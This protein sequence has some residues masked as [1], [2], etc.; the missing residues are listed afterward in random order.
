MYPSRGLFLRGLP[1]GRHRVH[2]PAILVTFRMATSTSFGSGS[3]I[4]RHCSSVGVTEST[5]FDEARRIGRSLSIA[6]ARVQVCKTKPTYPQFEGEKTLDVLVVGG[7]ITGLTAAYLLAKAGKSVALFERRTIGAGNTGRTTAH[8]Q[9]EV[10][11]YYCELEKIHGRETARLVGESQLAAV[12]FIER[13]T[14]EGARVRIR[15]LRFDPPGKRTGI[16]ERELHA[17]RRCG[18]KVDFV[19]RAPLEHFDTGRCLRFAGMGQFHPLK[20]IGGLADAA[21]RHGASIYEGTEM[22]RLENPSAEGVTAV[23][24]RA[25]DGSVAGRVRARRLVL[26]TCSPPHT[27]I[28]GDALLASRM[29]PSRT[30]VLAL[31]VPRGALGPPRA[32][33]WDTEDPYHYVRLKSG[34]GAGAGGD[35]VL[36]VGGE[37]HRT[38]RT[39]GPYRVRFDRL[40]ARAYPPPPPVLPPPPPLGPPKRAA[41]GGTQAWARERFPMCR[42]VVHRWS[43]QARPVQ[44]PF[45]G[46]PFVGQAPLSYPSVLVATGDSGTGMTNGTMASGP[47]T[48][49]CPPPPRLPRLA[50]QPLPLAI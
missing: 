24:L 10:D 45:D 5:W 17:A 16:L 20:Y 21:A 4:P 6:I 14:R 50:S 34:A 39:P 37:D 42:D 48:S 31:R 44:E 36:I 2:R 23:A 40:E 1:L 43:G 18:L 41:A 35:D 15:I 9:I 26:A 25:G 38:G 11:D 49:S 33:F 22:G 7:G 28:V 12:D 8:L 13:V 27:N 47:T 19:D 30:Y 29:S 46:L 3:T 32:L